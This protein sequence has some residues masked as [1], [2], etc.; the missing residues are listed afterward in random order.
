MLRLIRQAPWYVPN[1]ILHR[2]L[3]VAPVREIFKEKAKAHRKTL[4]SHPNSIM[5]PLTT[6]P[7]TWTVRRKWTFDDI[8]QEEIAGLLLDTVIEP[9]T[10]AYRNSV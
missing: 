7:Q 10:L 3:C 8:K 6:Q 5:R 1:Q 9:S 4:S 2:E